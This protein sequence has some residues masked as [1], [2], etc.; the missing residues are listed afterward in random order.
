MPATTANLG[1]GYDVIGMA[2]DMWSEIRVELSEEF[3][4]VV[5]GESADSFRTD[6][7]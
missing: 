1:S 2:L 6:E 7:V 5:E 3:E 4:V